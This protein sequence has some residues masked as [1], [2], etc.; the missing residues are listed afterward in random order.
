M[1]AESLPEGKEAISCC[2]RL[3]WSTGFLTGIDLSYLCV[4]CMALMRENIFPYGIYRV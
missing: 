1:V 4:R 2:T 3:E